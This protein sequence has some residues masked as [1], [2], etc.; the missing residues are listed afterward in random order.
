MGGWRKWLVGGALG[1]AALVVVWA[2]YANSTL[3]TCHDLTRKVGEYRMGYGLKQMMNLPVDAESKR[4]FRALC[5]DYQG[6][7]Q[8]YLDPDV[9]RWCS[10]P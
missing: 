4:R 9:V 1:F 3:G 10:L 2:A 5:V 7:C 8:A 6:Q